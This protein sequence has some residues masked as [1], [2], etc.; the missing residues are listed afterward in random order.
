MLK[1]SIFFLILFV[2]SGFS[3]CGQKLEES[4]NKYS[5]PSLG[6]SFCAPPKWTIIKKP[7]QLYQQVN[8]EDKNGKSSNINV[9][10]SDYEGDLTAL[11][12]MMTNELT[13]N[14][15]KDNGYSYIKFE[16]KAEFSA[17]TAKRLF[18]FF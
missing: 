13:T 8:G 6:I 12:V 11:A 18:K 5:E 17:K 15:A 16:S 10:A 3:A 7:N 9:V 14:Y 1:N 2:A 4:C